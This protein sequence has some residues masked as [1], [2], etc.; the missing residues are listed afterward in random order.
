MRQSGWQYGAGSLISLCW[1][2]GVVFGELV[3][4]QSSRLCF[5]LLTDMPDSLFV[6]GRAQTPYFSTLWDIHSLNNNK[7]TAPVFLPALKHKKRQDTRKQVS[8]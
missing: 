5:Q 4:V 8:V 6:D 2:K 7:G 1:L 3:C